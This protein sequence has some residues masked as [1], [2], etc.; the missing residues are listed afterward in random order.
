MNVDAALRWPW[1]EL[2]AAMQVNAKHSDKQDYS[3]ITEANFEGVLA[4]LKADVEAD[5]GK[6]SRLDDTPEAE[7]PRTNSTSSGPSSSH[8]SETHTLV[9]ADL[10]TSSG[11][12]SEV[13]ACE[14][15]IVVEAATRDLCSGLMAFFREAGS[16]SP[17]QGDESEVF[18][19][20]PGSLHFKAII[21]FDVTP[22]DVEVR[23]FE[24][25]NVG[26][27]AVLSHPSRSDSVRFVQTFQLA[28]E[29]LATAGFKVLQPHGGVRDSCLRLLEDDM[30]ISDDNWSEDDDVVD[31][32]EGSQHDL[33]A[34][35]VPRCAS[36]EHDCSPMR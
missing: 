5:S 21:F 12:H 19:V 30:S 14:W 26:S 3:K 6:L 8:T 25:D 4:W 16:R 7:A 20:A 2:D 29:H 9:Q 36:G 33:R 15:K 32:E 10:T 28:A 17:G 11:Y 24:V 34:W 13:S 23:V 27:C 35:E 1:T 18:E 22:V 31:R